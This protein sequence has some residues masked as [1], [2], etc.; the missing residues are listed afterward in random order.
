MT[1]FKF[2]DLFAG[3]GGFRSALA[4]LGGRCV[5]TNE[6]DKFAAQTYQAWYGDK[7]ISTEDIRQVRFEN[8]PDHDILCA[9]FPCQPFSIAGVSKKQSLG[10]KHGF[11][12]ETQG[13]LFFA[14][15]D[16]AK[17]KRPKILLLENVKNLRSHDKGNTMKVIEEQINSI[18]Y[19]LFSEVIS[20]KTVVPQNR[21][22]IFMVAFDVQIFGKD[23]DF[24]FPRFEGETITLKGIL[25]KNV[26]QKYTLSD[27]LWSYLEG[28]DLKQKEKGNGFGYGLVGPNDVARTMSAR[29][30][31]DGAEILITQKKKNPRRLTPKEAK[32][33]MGFCDKYAKFFGHKDG[34]PQVVSDAQSYKQFGN[35]VVP[36]VVEKIAKEIL[37]KL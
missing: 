21:Q 11:D 20:S 17:T 2:I 16:I 19:K 9:G 15:R 4:Y 14:I 24:S 18:G 29:Y 25:E 35:S 5:Y 3:I 10:R 7:D 27:N 22:R 8:I 31:K 13:N 36:L 6:W 28:Y 33:L 23:I 30:Y 32:Y 1:K 12:D 34:F 26:E 37:K